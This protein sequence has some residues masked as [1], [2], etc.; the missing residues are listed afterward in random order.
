MRQCLNSLR[1]TGQ[2]EPLLEASKK[3]PKRKRTCK[4]TPRKR[5]GVAK[6]TT[7]VVGNR[8]SA[9][10]TRQNGEGKGTS[11]A[12]PK[13]ADLT[14]STGGDEEEIKDSSIGNT[15]DDYDSDERPPKGKRTSKAAPRKR[16]GVGTPT[17]LVVG[18]PSSTRTTRQK[19]KGKGKA[20]AAPTSANLTS[21]TGNDDEEEVDEGSVTNV[22]GESGDR[23][24]KLSAILA[25]KTLLPGEWK[26]IC[27]DMNTGQIT[28]GS[29][30]KQE[31]DDEATA[32][33]QKY[34]V[35]WDGKSYLHV[36]WEV[37]TD[38]VELTSKTNTQL[39]RVLDV[40][41]VE[42]QETRLL[43]KW[44]GSSYSLCTYEL[45]SDLNNAGLKTAEAVE[46]YHRREDMKSFVSLKATRKVADGAPDLDKEPPV[47]KNGGSLRDYQR[48]GVRWMI[49]NWLQGRGSILA[50]EMGL[51]KTLQTVASLS[52]VHNDYGKRG[53]FLVIALLS[54]VP[55]W[56]REFQTW[57]DMNAV[58][59]HGD[60]ED[61]EI[62]EGYEMEFAGDKGRAEKDKTRIKGK[63]V[64]KSTVVIT[65][66]KLCIR[67][68]VKA[69]LQCKITWDV[70][71]VDKAHRL[72]NSASRL[73]VVLKDYT[74][75]SSLL[76][77]GT[78]LQN[79][80]KELW[81]LLNL[82]DQP[83]F[84]D[85]RG[86]VEK[87]GDL[88]VRQRHRVL[89][90]Q[91]SVR[92]MDKV[93]IFDISAL[94][95]FLQRLA[96][97]PSP[98]IPA[99]NKKLYTQVIQP[100]ANE[101]S[102][103]EDVSELQEEIK[104]YLLRRMKEDVEKAVLP[105]EEIIIEVELTEIQK[106]YYRAIY[107]RNTTFL[108]QGKKQAKDAPSLMNLAMQLRKCYNHPYLI[109]RIFS[110]LQEHLVK[111]SGKLVLLDKLLPR[112]KTQGHRVLLF[113]QFK[114]ID[115]FQAPDSDMLV[116]LLSTRAGGV[117][118]TLTA[119]DTCII[120]D[121]DWNP[122]ANYLT[123][124]SESSSEEE[125]EDEAYVPNPQSEEDESSGDE[126]AQ[127][128]E[129]AVV[130]K[131]THLSS[132]NVNTEASKERSQSLAA[133]AWCA[134][135][136]LLGPH[137]PVAD[138]SDDDQSSAGPD[139]AT[140][141]TP[142]NL[143]QD[144][145]IERDPVA[146]GADCCLG[147]KID[148]GVDSSVA[149]RSPR[150]A[151][152]PGMSPPP[153]GAAAAARRA[154][155]NFNLMEDWDDFFRR[156]AD[157]A[158]SPAPTSGKCG[159]CLGTA[160]DEQQRV[161]LVCRRCLVCQQRGR[162]AKSYSITPAKSYSM[163]A[164]HEGNFV[165]YLCFKKAVRDAE[166]PSDFDEVRGRF[167]PLCGAVQAA[168]V[169]RKHDKQWKGSGPHM[170]IQCKK[171]L[172]EV[173]EAREKQEKLRQKYNHEDDQAWAANRKER[174]GSPAK[175]FNWAS[176]SGSSWGGEDGREESTRHGPGR[177]TA[178]VS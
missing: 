93:Q 162:D 106:Q 55:D 101:L 102:E 26:E 76:L 83:K 126:F 98:E 57:S 137:V 40:D 167:L 132:L 99:L 70:L 3:S 30:W 118:I 16:Q 12:T 58:V 150:R 85:Q 20:I 2:P 131:G 24:P 48:E 96:R 177:G 71:V 144:S 86:V 160:T 31:E 135:E 91:C 113:S 69:L 66:P 59:F 171:H 8:V 158:P 10:T 5:Q 38:L 95:L 45:V 133:Q 80:T 15:D 174:G 17:T 68:D 79:N 64:W 121:S 47:F 176:A 37:S 92:F 145:F 67:K 105:K 157:P 104:S 33:V 41:R 124:D 120:Y 143:N 43:V 36:S 172:R 112:L 18:S 155:D 139:P 125:S 159:V 74:I 75:E 147:R 116:M 151:S 136:R 142:G 153:V 88:P 168:R 44:A 108:L 32:P 54:T 53:P 4:A 49:H 100:G 109:T 22:D 94:L 169:Q 134:G 52:I 154:A 9:R 11:K 107:D 77:T 115:S 39:K 152:A 129:K 82:V 6:P 114:E 127:V 1:V 25:S 166:V 46:A 173:D 111:H 7:K 27:K 178:R 163:I 14:P 119:A 175:A 28:A 103:A 156:P 117:G 87:Y 73:N 170:T 23:P 65:S 51:G 130:L 149:R 164:T 21:S 34:L 42:G 72:K 29:M 148:A 61:R 84:R 123:T 60:K 90:V 146:P 35:K 141:E 50:D 56:L 97:G 140:T 138:D 89:D 122:Q 62:L 63:R 110:R 128:P 161:L 81:T 78:P 165:H 13:S 19:G